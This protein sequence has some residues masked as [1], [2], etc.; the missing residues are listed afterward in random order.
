MLEASSSGR[1]VL[2]SNIP[3][4]REAV[5]DGRTGLLFKP[6]DEESLYNAVVKFCEASREDREKMGC[7]AREKMEKEF[8]RVNVV[9]KYTE[10]IESL[11]SKN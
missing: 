5:E 3:G 8:D 7:L 4:C 10:K 9:N 11:S 1:P 2:A 6:R